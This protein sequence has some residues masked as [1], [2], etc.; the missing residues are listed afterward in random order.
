M[1]SF[2]PSLSVPAAVW[3]STVV[4]TKKAQYNPQLKAALLITVYQTSPRKC[5]LESTVDNESMRKTLLDKLQKPPQSNVSPLG[6]FFPFRVKTKPKR[7]TLLA[8]RTEHFQPSVVPSGN[9]P[10]PTS[11]LL[12]PPHTLLPPPHFPVLYRT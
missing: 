12:S 7:Q 9:A 11:S 1:A 3:P 6:Q 10:R 4:S 8:Q 2:Q 5:Y